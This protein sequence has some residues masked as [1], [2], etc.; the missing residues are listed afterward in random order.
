MT[1][2]AIRTGP[3]VFALPIGTTRIGRAPESEIRIEDESVSRA[4]AILEVESDS[5][6]LHESGSRNGVRVNGALRRGTIE[7]APGDKIQIGTAELVLVDRAFA[8]EG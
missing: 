8:E 1:R 3:H 6:V 5:V 2:F 7:L 4:H